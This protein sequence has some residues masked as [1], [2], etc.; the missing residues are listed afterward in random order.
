MNYYGLVE[1]K[2][3]VWD[4]PVQ[5]ETGSVDIDIAGRSGERNL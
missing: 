3:V 4:H 1:D 2:C 5:T